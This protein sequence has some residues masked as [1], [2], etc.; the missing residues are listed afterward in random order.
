[1]LYTYQVRQNTEL[2]LTRR[3]NT[4]LFSTWEAP[5]ETDITARPWSMIA[6]VEGTRLAGKFGIAQVAIRNLEFRT[7]MNTDK[8]YPTTSGLNLQNSSRMNIQD[9]QI[10]L[11]KNIGDAKLKKELLANPCHTAGLI[12]SGN[13][14]A[15]LIFPPK[16]SR[17][18]ILSIRSGVA[19]RPRRICGL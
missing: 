5:E 13:R 17:I 10:C 12:A 19:V 14:I 2:Q 3:V 4:F 1:M 8:M 7:P 15:A 11:D 9:S 18:S 6:T 16:Y